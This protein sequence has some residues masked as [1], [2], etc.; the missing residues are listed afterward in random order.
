MI[1]VAIPRFTL[2]EYL[3]LEGVSEVCHEFYR[4]KRFVMAEATE[5]H[6]RIVLNMAAGLMS[7]LRGHPCRVL[8]LDL[9]VQVQ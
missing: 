9:R 5:A 8:A 6:N 3:A 1:A 4:G 2:E 7:E